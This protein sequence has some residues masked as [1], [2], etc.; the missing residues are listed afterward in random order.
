MSGQHY[1]GSNF[2]A[3]VFCY[4]TCFFWATPR[5]IYL[6]CSYLYDQIKLHQDY[7]GDVIKAYNQALKESSKIK[8]REKA[9]TNFKLYKAMYEK[10]KTF[11]KNRYSAYGE[12]EANYRVSKIPTPQIWFEINGMPCM[13]VLDDTSENLNF[14]IIANKNQTLG[15]GMYAPLGRIIYNNQLV[16]CDSESWENEWEDLG[17][18]ARRILYT[19][20]SGNFPTYHILFKE[21]SPSSR[22]KMIRKAINSFK[23]VRKI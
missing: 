21:L 10:N 12:E 6:V 11:V 13:N 20:E 18:N 23:Q 7:P 16:Y 3:L 22:K 1:T 14:V 2:G 9:L 4:L 8:G 19:L 17:V 5:F 15:N